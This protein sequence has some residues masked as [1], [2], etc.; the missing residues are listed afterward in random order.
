VSTSNQRPAGVS[1]TAVEAAP[2]LWRTD[3]Q[4]HDLSVAGRE[5]V[6]TRVEIT[7]DSPPIRHSHPGE[8]VIYVVAGAL[9]YDIEGQPTMVSNAGDALTIPAGVVH[10]VSNAGDGIAIEL[11][12]YV[13]EK[14]KPLLTVVK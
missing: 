14:G 2:G 11:A 10:A 9:Q 13:V 7:P 12:T 3:L 4:K 5:V 6:Q 1:K 8:E